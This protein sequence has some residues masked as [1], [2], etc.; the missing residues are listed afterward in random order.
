[1]TVVLSG[2]KNA[3]IKRVRVGIVTS[4]SFCVAPFISQLLGNSQQGA[5]LKS[6]SRA[7]CKV[8]RRWQ[9]R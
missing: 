7:E 6:W 3:I 8:E 5:R 9:L 4:P 1:M 2:K